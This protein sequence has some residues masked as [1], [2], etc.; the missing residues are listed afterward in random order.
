MLIKKRVPR[1][2]TCDLMI[3]CRED[4]FKAVM[5]Q[6]CMCPHVT[7]SISQL[8]LSKFITHNKW[9]CYKDE[10]KK[11]NKRY[12]HIGITVCIVTFFFLGCIVSI[13]MPA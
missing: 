1:E 12:I 11:K 3:A 4:H 10:E 7:F 8:S 9:L 5:L 13:V 2:D 6:H